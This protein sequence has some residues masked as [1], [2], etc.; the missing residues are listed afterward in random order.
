VALV[1]LRG[2]LRV[3]GGRGRGRQGGLVV[4]V[5]VL[6][7]LLVLVLRLLLGGRV[8]RG[9]RRALLRLLLRGLLRLGLLRRLR[10][11]GPV[12]GVDLAREGS[13]NLPRGGE[14]GGRQLLRLDAEGLVGE[15]AEANVLAGARH[16]NPRGPR[17]APLVPVHPGVVGAR[18]SRRCRGCG[19]GGLLVLVL[20]R[21]CRRGRHLCVYMGAR[22]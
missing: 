6:L 12:R 13:D 14:L 10:G 16:G 22:W 2:L 7:V 17:A 4:L 11:R 19:G 15:T 5:L 1:G 3:L 20:L 9:P 21:R 18:L 8:R